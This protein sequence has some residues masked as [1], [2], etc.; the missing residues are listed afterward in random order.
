MTVRTIGKE[1]VPAF[2][3]MLCRLDEETEYMMYE[4]GERRAR[5]K[6][7][8]RLEAVVFSAVSGEDFLQVAEND[9][10]EI[11]GFLHAERGRMNRIRHTAYIVIGIRRSYRCQGIG[12]HLLRNLF[13]WAGIH[14]IIRLEL[15]VEC[16]NTAAK[17]LY[18]KQGFAVE[19]LRKKAMNVNGVFVD[20]YA[21]AKIIE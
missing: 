13:D 16:S 19:G 17:H 18:E 14:G 20:E 11:V 2:F 15:T 8:A 21:M 4:P 12:T 9:T 5:T 7:L 1:D 10:G 3:E 6:D